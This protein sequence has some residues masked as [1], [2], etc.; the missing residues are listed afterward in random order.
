MDRSDCARE[1]C[2]GRMHH[3]ADWDDDAGCWVPVDF[4]CPL[5]VGR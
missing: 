5:V 4:L 1:D 3:S 2:D